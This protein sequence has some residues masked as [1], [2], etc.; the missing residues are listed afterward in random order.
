MKNRELRDF[1][2]A[3]LVD[4]AINHPN[5][6]IHQK[7]D[8]LADAITEFVSKRISERLLEDKPEKDE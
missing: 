1:I 3:E 5:I 6:S 2:E 4:L 7:S 8:V